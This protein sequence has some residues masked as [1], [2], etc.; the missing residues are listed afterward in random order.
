MERT[1]WKSF[2]VGGDP[3]REAFLG[4]ELYNELMNL[5]NVGWQIVRVD[6]NPISRAWSSNRKAYVDTIQYLIIA[7]AEEEEDIGDVSQE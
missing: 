6:R 1:I 4:A 2:E 7:K 5:Q 3:D